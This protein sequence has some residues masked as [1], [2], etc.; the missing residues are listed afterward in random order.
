MTNRSRHE[1]Y[2]SILQSASQDRD[3][4]IL[5]KLMYNTFLSYTQIRECLGELMRFGLIENQTDTSKYRVTEK[6]YR[7]LHLF[8]E[9]E[10]ISKDS[11]SAN[12]ILEI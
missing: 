9:I 3:G 2:A 11:S 6:G 10:Q 8:E 5:T 4:M 7:F 1:I 12:K